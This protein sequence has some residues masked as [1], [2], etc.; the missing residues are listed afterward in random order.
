MSGDL[1]RLDR[2]GAGAGPAAP[3][4][5]VHIGPGAFFRA[6][7]AWYTAHASSEWGIAAVSGRSPA[8]LESLGPQG[9]CY[10]LLTR[11]P[12]R[13]EAEVVASISEVVG[14]DDPRAL[15]LV[16]SPEVSV[17]TLTITEAGYQAGA[18]VLGR[19]LAGLERRRAAG[20]GPLTVV[21]CDNLAGNGEVLRAAVLQEAPDAL[22]S[23]I[24]RSCAFPSTVVD[25]ITPAT[26]PQD[27]EVVGER[28]GWDDWA[29]AVTEPFSEWILEDRFVGPRPPWERAGARLVGDVAPFEQ[30]KLRLL[31]AGHSLLAYRGLARGH[32]F[33]HEAMSD[34]AL[35]GAV[36]ELWAETRRWMLPAALEGVDGY[37]ATVETRWAN[38]RL[39]HSLE[40]IAMDGSLKLRQRLVPTVREA[41]EDGE[42]PVACAGLLGA[43]V[44]HVRSTPDLHDAQAARLRE[45]SAG[46][47]ADA[48]R[49]LLTV[50]D[51]ALA[52]DRWLL[53]T[54]ETAASEP[55]TG[56]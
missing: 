19:L 5:M 24:E 10:T 25:R 17:V 44:A 36:H 6:H 1:V 53:T 12:E 35:R 46:S 22:R 31:N 45:A 33:V 26:T 20:A 50:L 3:V 7:Q 47:L 28:M 51:S 2:S 16:A 29:V 55:I 18:P 11:G 37:C 39:P 13:D 23:W 27:R 54:V 56:A 14:P 9:G 41:R 48:T 49:A 32:R 52:T 15:D 21:A 34:E 43:W 38:T 42:E 4:R 40:Q 8:A 30:R